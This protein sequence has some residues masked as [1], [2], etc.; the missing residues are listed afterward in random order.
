LP[1]TTPTSPRWPRPS[2]G[3]GGGNELVFYLTAGS[4]LGGGLVK[5]GRIYHGASPGECELGHLRLDRQGTTL[6]SVASG[7]AVDARIREL[8]DGHPDSLLCQRARQTPGTEARHLNEALA[9]GDPLAEQLLA[10]TAGYLALGLSHVVHL[11]HPEV[12]VLGGGLSLVGEPLRQAIAEQVPALV[13]EAFHPVPPVRIAEL[14]EAAVPTGA[15]LLARQRGVSH[16][17]D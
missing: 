1:I 16:P 10:E 17:S 5:G 4:G 9:A 14:S 3:P 11:F 15:L 2:R 7:W 13:M 6:E 12:L 8:L